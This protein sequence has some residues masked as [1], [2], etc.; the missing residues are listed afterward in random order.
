MKRFFL[1]FLSILTI[2]SLGIN[3]AAAAN[4]PLVKP[5]YPKAA[6]Y[7]DYDARQKTEKDNPVDAAFLTSVIPQQ[8]WQRK[9]SNNGPAGS[10]TARLDHKAIQ[11]QKSR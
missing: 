2:A 1:L 6:A 11:I 7:N 9:R 8:Q 10:V 3:A 5:V 4:T